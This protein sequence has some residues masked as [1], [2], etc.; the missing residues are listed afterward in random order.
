MRRVEGLAQELLGGCDV[1]AY[2]VRVYAKNRARK[3]TQTYT[4]YGF[5]RKIAGRARRKPLQGNDLQL[6]LKITYAGHSK[7]FGCFL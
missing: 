5:T 1:K 2:A 7:I 3:L 6:S 4:V